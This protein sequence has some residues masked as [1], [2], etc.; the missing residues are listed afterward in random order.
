M[1][2]A[3]LCIALLC[4]WGCGAEHTASAP[5]PQEQ[6]EAERT[7]ALVQSP[8]IN[9]W[10]RRVIYFALVD[11]FANGDITNDRANGVAACNGDNIHIYQGGDLAGLTGR[12]DYIRDLG[13][14]ALWITPLYE[15]VDVK[16]GANCGFP[17]YWADFA[18]PY[19]LKLDG[20]FG[21]PDEF[22]TLIDVA[23]DEGL[24]VMLDMVVNHAG[25]EA[26]LVEQRPEWFTDPA[27]CWQQGN[28]EIYCSL[29][30]LPDFDHRRQ[31]VRD[32]LVDLHQQW[33]R[34]FD[35]DGIRMDTVK[36]VEPGYF[37]NDWLPAM[38]AERPSL[39]IIGELLNEGSLD[40]L[41]PYLDAGF[42]GLFNFPLRR[43]LI[44]T[45]AKGGSV[46][47]SAGRMA[48]TLNRFGADQA[49]LMVNLL[50]NHDVPRFLEEMPWGL[51][52]AESQQRYLLAMTALLTLP[53]VPQIYYGNE[54]GMYG[55]HDPHNRRF[56]PDWAF[57][58]EGRAQSHSGYLP[59]PDVVFDY[60]RQLLAIRSQHPALALG[61]YRELW[62]QNGHHNANVWS[63]L[64]SEG[65]DQVV[66]AYNNGSRWTD[67]PLPVQVGDVFPDGTI[68]DD[69]LGRAG[70]GPFVV[71]D[72]LLPLELPGRS[73]V[74]LVPRRSPETPVEMGV[75]TV[76]FEVEAHTYWGQSVYLTGSTAPLGGWDLN[77][78]RKMSPSDCQGTQCRWTLEMPLGA[79]GEVEF[80]FVKIDESLHVVWE[81]GANRVIRVG[82]DQASYQGGA[83]R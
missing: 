27:T 80:K 22:D 44:D 81:H 75:T 43:S 19:E 55:G 30:G 24:L 9:D 3:T 32:Y 61:R 16:A 59:E 63:Y 26:Q 12:L 42:D 8:E 50:D 78:A 54:I 62:R 46:D 69:V 76:H 33:V 31:D 21:R 7:E 70:A 68:L 72:G 15:G 5:D 29:A 4:L 20:R 51:S 48:E 14:S 18:D 71:R 37:G 39:Y 74:I 11:R 34:R 40:P 64:R 65:E 66:V 10:R 17:G 57:R 82:P 13:A 25:Y 45:F 47:I 77:T 52:G 36:H 79:G 58:A 6:T 49:G 28:P 53:G 60:T 23:H 67:G 83:F 41:H 35:F 1:M 38:R 73:A 56:M 2:R